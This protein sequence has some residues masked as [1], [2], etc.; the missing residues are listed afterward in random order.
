[1]WTIEA[2]ITIIYDIVQIEQR[3]YAW[4]LH[5]KSLSIKW[6]ISILRFEGFPWNP[7]ALILKYFNKDRNLTIQRGDLLSINVKGEKTIYD[8]S[9][10][11]TRS[12]L[13]CFTIEYMLTTIECIVMSKMKILISLKPLETKY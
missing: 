13:C 2:E 11:I 3:A 5:T 9:W 12:W 4:L 6:I 8:W 7:F 1:M 10:R